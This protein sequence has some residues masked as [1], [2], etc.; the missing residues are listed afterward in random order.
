MLATIATARGPALLL[1][2]ACGLTF[3]AHTAPVAAEEQ[4]LRFKLV[5][6][7]LGKPAELPE[8]GGH[9]VSANE[10]TGV[11]VFE[12]G[13]IAYKR[14][15]ELDDSTGDVGTFTGYSTYTFQAGDSLT[16][17]Y[18][19]GFDTTGVTGKY[20]VISGTGEFAGATGTGEFR[21][22]EAKWDEA[23]LL[24]GSFRVTLAK[25]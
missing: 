4:T 25:Q 24:D 16:L 9:K 5:V 23:L 18:T 12:D 7:P 8:I 21:S 22:V 11:A 13:R 3:L 6:R 1:T 10:Y 2:A 20:Q 17:S 19:G 15:V 14:F